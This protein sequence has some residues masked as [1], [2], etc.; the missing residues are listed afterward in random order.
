MFI[1]PLYYYVGIN[2]TRP[3]SR[4]STRRSSLCRKSQRRFSKRDK[5]N[6]TMIL[7][8]RQVG[9]SLWRGPPKELVRDNITNLN[10]LLNKNGS[11]ILLQVPFFIIY[12]KVIVLTQSL[13]LRLLRI[14]Y[15]LRHYF[16]FYSKNNAKWPSRSEILINMR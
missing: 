11:S 5:S 2:V 9:M 12:C 4:C 7:F 15:S 13:A 6:R 8:A 14:I 1:F 10:M 16:P 3:V